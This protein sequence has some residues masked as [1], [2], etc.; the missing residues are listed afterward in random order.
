MKVRRGHVGMIPLF[1]LNLERF[2]PVQFD[3]ID[4]YVVHSRFF[5]PGRSLSCSQGQLLLPD[6]GLTCTSSRGD[7]SNVPTSN[8]ECSSKTD[9]QDSNHLCHLSWKPMTVAPAYGKTWES[10]W[11]L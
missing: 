5:I 11:A 6:E 9:G 8:E 7:S 2:S 1:K 4:L 3:I 10:T